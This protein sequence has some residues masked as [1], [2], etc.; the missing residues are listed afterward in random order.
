[1]PR[2]TISQAEFFARHPEMDARLK[3]IGR[4]AAFRR[5]ELGLTQRQVATTLGITRPQLSGFENGHR[6]LQ[7]PQ[8]LYLVLAL[9]IDILGPDVTG[10]ADV[11]GRGQ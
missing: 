9:G 7:L 11:E 6:R 2:V 4:R 3:A 5:A 1:M 10:K 8:F